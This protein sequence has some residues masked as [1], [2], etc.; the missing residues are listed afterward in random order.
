VVF[1]EGLPASFL[2]PLVRDDPEVLVDQGD[3]LIE[4]F[5]IAVRPLQEETGDVR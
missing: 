2:Q 3:E 5:S 4:G 1:R